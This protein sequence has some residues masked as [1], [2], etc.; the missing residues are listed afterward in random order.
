MDLDLKIVGDWEHYKAVQNIKSMGYEVFYK[1]RAKGYGII[2]ILGTREGSNGSEQVFVKV[3]KAS[4]QVILPQEFV[5][6]VRK[7]A[8]FHAFDPYAKMIIAFKSGAI[9]LDDEMLKVLDYYNIK[10]MQ[11]SPP[12]HP[13]GGPRFFAATPA[14]MY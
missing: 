5:K 10:P 2:D 11:L 7:F 1:Y 3:K 8:R 6:V 9:E 13:V 12:E 14:S 4:Y